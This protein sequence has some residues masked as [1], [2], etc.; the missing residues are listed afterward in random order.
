[1]T[2]MSNATTRGWVLCGAL[3]ATAAF[4]I[5]ACVDERIVYRNTN[6]TQPPAAAANFIGYGDE[7]TKQTVCGNCH[8]ERQTQWAGT[9]HSRAWSDLQGSGHASGTCEACHTVNDLGNS[10]TDTAAG[11]RSTRDARYHDVQCESCHGPGLTHVSSPSI[12]NQ[13]LATLA[14]DTTLTT[15]CAACHHGAHQPFEDE[16]LHSAHALMPQW[17]GRA[18]PQTRAECQGCHTGQGALA[19]WGVRTAYAEAGFAN[20]DTLQITCGVCHD[21]HDATNP[22]QLRFP[23]DV[24]DIQTNLCMK[25]HQRGPT[26]DP[27]T[28]AHGPHSPEGPLLLGD[29]GWFPPNMNVPGGID[30]LVATHG[31]SAN[32]GLCATCH[33][34]RFTVTDTATGAFTLQVV[35]HTFEA[36]PCVNAQGG[37]TTDT[38]CT[39]SQRTFRACTASGCHGSENAARSAFQVVEQRVDQLTEQLQTQLNTVLAAT[40]AETSS[41]SGVW[42]TAQGSLFNLRLAERTGSFIHNPFLVEALLTASIKQMSTDYGV[43]ADRRIPLDNILQ[44]LVVTGAAAASVAQPSERPVAS[45]RRDR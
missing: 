45:T 15:G 33:V 40:P 25:C 34:N 13:P 43:S 3:V 11:W 1:M 5:A 23:I 41:T 9:A 30:T 12:S 10:V 35:G 7:A 8:V 2:V 19:A 32:P 22:K 20:G 42:T 21:P 24:A 17:K 27:S 44:K 31:S 37:L 4:A 14:V 18:A 29:A 16:W 28:S 36:I 26:L 6:F 38:T 39:L